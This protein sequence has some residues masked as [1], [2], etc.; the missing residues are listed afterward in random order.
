MRVAALTKGLEGCRTRGSLGVRSG[1]WEVK[2]KVCFIGREDLSVG[3]GSF[4][5]LVVE[6]GSEG[7]PKNVIKYAFLI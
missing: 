6:V 5:P 1:G 3:L 7:F 4:S 2:A